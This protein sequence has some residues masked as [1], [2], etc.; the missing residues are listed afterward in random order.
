MYLKKK[1]FLT[2]NIIKRVLCLKNKFHKSID[3]HTLRWKRPANMPNVSAAIWWVLVADKKKVIFV[4]SQQTI[5]PVF[6]A[7]DCEKETK[8]CDGKW[9][10]NQPIYSTIENA[11]LLSI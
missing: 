2:K 4:V 8:K 1:S 5:K 7:C 6:K 9:M 3:G 10:K 11:L